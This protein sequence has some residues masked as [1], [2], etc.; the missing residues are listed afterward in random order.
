MPRPLRILFTAIAFGV[1]FGGSILIAVLLFPFIFLLA[2]GNRA[3][4]RRWC[5]RFVG[6]G[7]G[8]F[9]FFMRS[10][11]LLTHNRLEPPEELRGKPY[12]MI[13]NHP[14]LIDVLFLL[15][16]FP[17]LTCV[18][19]NAWYGNFSFGLVLRS[20]DYVG[21][22][23]AEESQLGGE[24]PALERMIAHVKA[25]NPLM[26]FPEGTRSKADRLNRLRRGPFHIAKAC[27]VPLVRVFIRVDR[28]IL[29]KGAPIWH[30]PEDRAQWQFEILDVID[31]AEDPRDAEQLRRDVQDDYKRRFN[32]WLEERERAKALAEDAV[33]AKG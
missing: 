28:P 2:I 27:G 6:V 14:T 15:H 26:M 7:Y 30:V 18:V 20:T 31:T 13:A 1:F 17:R 4:H 23:S 24:S 9:I 25:G 32:L 22:P 11:G 3:R 33:P 21:G 12:V 29:M 5:T 8:T 10:M 19:K 16:W